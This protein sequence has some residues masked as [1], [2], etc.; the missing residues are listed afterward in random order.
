MKKKKIIKLIERLKNEHDVLFYQK[1]INALKQEL[2]VKSSINAGLES[3]VNR[4]FIRQQIIEKSDQ[5]AQSSPSCIGG[6]THG[7]KSA[8]CDAVGPIGKKMTNGEAKKALIEII[9][10]YFD[11]STSIG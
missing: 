8:E 6:C 3:A 11:S 2:S 9:N 5:D 7:L 4:K 10:N 1:Q